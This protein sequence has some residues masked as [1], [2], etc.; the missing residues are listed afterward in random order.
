ME[1]LSRRPFG[2]TARRSF[3]VV[4]LLVGGCLAGCANFSA[5]S[6]FAK[7]TTSMTGTARTELND[8]D[9]LCHDQAELTIIV[10]AITDD[11]PIKTCDAFRDAQGRFAAVTLDV[12]DA[13]ATALAALANDSSFDVSTAIETLGA[14]VQGLKTAGGQSIANEAQ[15]NAIS[16]LLDIVGEAVTQHERKAAVER[17]VAEKD[18]VKT[19]GRVLRSFFARDPDAPTAAPFPPYVTIV[20]LTFDALASTDRTLGLPQFRNAEPIRTLELTRASA[21]RRQQLL[22][23]SGNAP[24]MPPATVVAMIDSWLVAV[25]IFAT[26]AFRPDPQQLLKQLQD[27]RKKALDAKAAVKT[28]SH[29]G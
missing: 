17:L 23:R 20:A 16:R 14:Q 7:T 12:L 22:G 15:V 27:V 13:Y 6:N 19:C 8:L 3:E 25:D 11:G 1:I 29:G 28:L 2:T 4:A 10:N 9:R 24:D 18:D 5:V 21:A 26:E